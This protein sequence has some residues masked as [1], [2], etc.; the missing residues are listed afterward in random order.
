MSSLIDEF[1]RHSSL[2]VMLTSRPHLQTR[3]LC[4]EGALRI[5]IHAQDADIRTYLSSRLE[6]ASYLSQ[7]FKKDIVEVIGDGADGM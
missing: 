5:T 4:P 6:K 2:R 7:E 1:M 3:S